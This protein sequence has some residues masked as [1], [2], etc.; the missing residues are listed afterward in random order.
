[1]TGNDSWSRSLICFSRLRGPFDSSE[2]PPWR[3]EVHGI[4]GSFS[5]VFWSCSMNT[6]ISSSTSSPRF[7]LAASGVHIVGI[8]RSTSSSCLLALVNPLAGDTRLVPPAMASTPSRGWWLHV[9]ESCHFFHRRVFDQSFDFI[10]LDTQFWTR[11]DGSDVQLM[12]SRITQLAALI[13]PAHPML[14]PV[15]SNSGSLAEVPDPRPSPGLAAPAFRS[16]YKLSC[17]THNEKHKKVKK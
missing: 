4:C 14:S 12:T 15:R 16:S 10:F 13:D 6:L 17:D 1:M 9:M 7:G 5:T 11:P 8:A 2:R 3:L